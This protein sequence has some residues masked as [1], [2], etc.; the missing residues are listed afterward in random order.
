M[1][2]MKKIIGVFSLIFCLVLVLFLIVFGSVVILGQVIDGDSGDSGD[3]RDFRLD[4]GNGIIEAPNEDDIIE[5]CDD[6]NTEDGDGCS[7][8]CMIEVIIEDI[9]CDD[10][11]KPVCKEIE[12]LETTYENGCPIYRCVPLYLSSDITSCGIINQPGTYKLQNNIEAVDLEQCILIEASNVFINGNGKII[13]GNNTDYGIYGS[14]LSFIT[15]YNLKLNSFDDG[16]YLK[17]Y[18]D[19]IRIS[20]NSIS[21]NK[22][23]IFLVG[24]NLVIS[25]NNFYSN[26]AA[27]SSSYVND[28]FILSNNINNNNVGVISSSSYN[29]TI[30]DNSFNRNGHG[31]FLINT[32]TNF[33]ISKNNF[34]LDDFDSRGIRI[35]GSSDFDVYD[36][37]IIDRNNFSSVDIPQNLPMDIGW[38]GDEGFANDWVISNN[39]FCNASNLSFRLTIYGASECSFRGT[40]NLINNFYG[41]CYDVEL[42]EDSGQYQEIVTWPVLGVHYEK[43]GGVVPDGGDSGGDSGD[44]TVPGGGGGSG[45]GSVPGGGNTFESCADLDTVSCGS[46]GAKWNFGESLGDYNLLTPGIIDFIEGTSINGPPGCDIDAT[47]FK[48]GEKIVDITSETG[49]GIFYNCECVHKSGLSGVLSGFECVSNAGWVETCGWDII[50][51]DDKFMTRYQDCIGKCE[52]EASTSGGCDLEMETISV[53]LK[54]NWKGTYTDKSTSCVDS[55]LSFDC[56]PVAGLSFFGLFNLFVC[57]FGIFVIYFFWGVLAGRAGGLK[58]K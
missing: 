23:G 50:N 44:G 27:I 13:T 19:N 26:D 14:D 29:L 49:C 22:I 8:E 17:G 35:D 30:S 37:F 43:C 10:V 20:V 54:A 55:S 4:C 28:L 57:V 45:G 5:E 39:D 9:M 56:A 48:C 21:R 3:S 25:G 15:I 18:N 34:I 7:S 41:G 6:G 31:I 47:K 1:K 51:Y 52:I 36:R 53:N 12:I 11:E 40:G 16:I 38:R 2:E 33:T 42:I 32:H 46:G 58:Q 24:S